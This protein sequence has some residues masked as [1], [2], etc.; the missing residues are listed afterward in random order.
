MAHSK[1][2]GRKSGNLRS[3]SGSGN[4]YS[5]LTSSNCQWPSSDFDSVYSFNNDSFS[6]ETENE[7]NENVSAANSGRANVADANA[8]EFNREFNPG[9]ETM[10]E[11][12]EI[13]YSTSRVSFQRPSVDSG[14]VADVN[15]QD[16]GQ[17]KEESE[18]ELVTENL[19]YEP[20]ELWSD[21]DVI[22][23]D[24]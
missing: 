9:R 11:R 5:E 16:I 20:P 7:Q 23:N 8:N 12:K 13:T 18:E 14:K 17:L 21:D 1:I 22:D 2:P 24:K 10:C 15:I 19:Y 3:K 4:V 6:P